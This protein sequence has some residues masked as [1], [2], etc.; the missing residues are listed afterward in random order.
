MSLSVLWS[1]DHYCKYSLLSWE[2]PLSDCM[3]VNEM[4]CPTTSD[5]FLI[6]Q[7]PLSGAVECPSGSYGKFKCVH[8]YSSH[9]LFLLLSV[10]G[11]VS[12]YT[13]MTS[14]SS[15]GCIDPITLCTTWELWSSSCAPDQLVKNLK[16]WGVSF[17]S[18]TCDQRVVSPMTGENAYD[19]DQGI[20]QQI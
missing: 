19:N 16:W 7:E 17:H 20:I 13:L 8:A 2:K 11:Q 1:L 3:Y 9:T 10:L 12:T 18:C 14:L 5:S 6:G 15:V 4:R